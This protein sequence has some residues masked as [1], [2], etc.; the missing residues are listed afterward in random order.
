MMIRL[1]D[2]DISL[3]TVLFNLNKIRQFYQEVNTNTKKHMDHE[4]TV[5]RQ[6]IYIIIAMLTNV[7]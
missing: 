7:S 3:V 5:N 6:H 2:D 1:F 4:Y